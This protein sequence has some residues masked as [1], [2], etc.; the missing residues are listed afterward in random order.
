MERA[1]QENVCRLRHNQLFRWAWGCARY[2]NGFGGAAHDRINRPSERMQFGLR[3]HT[4]VLP[5]SCLARNCRMTMPPSQNRDANPADT[6]NPVAPLYPPR[7]LVI[8]GIGS[9][10]VE[11]R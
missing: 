1:A 2:F 7:S 10:L 8:A 9:P 11:I 4:V 6:T 5:F 3:A